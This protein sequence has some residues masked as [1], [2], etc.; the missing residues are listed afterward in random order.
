MQTTKRIKSRNKETK[1]KTSTNKHREY[2]TKVASTENTQTHTHIA[3]TQQGRHYRSET[4]GQN[5]T[6]N[7]DSKGQKSSGSSAN[8]HAAE[9]MICGHVLI[10]S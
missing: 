1:Q 9:S 8:Y 3:A 7:D 6:E 5:I 4:N 2:N 10:S